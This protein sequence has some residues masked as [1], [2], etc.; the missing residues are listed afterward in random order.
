[1]Y[2]HYSHYVQ[3]KSVFTLTTLTIIIFQSKLKFEN[4]VL[5]KF[6]VKSKYL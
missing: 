3:F 4:K 6:T 2:F 5:V 1:M